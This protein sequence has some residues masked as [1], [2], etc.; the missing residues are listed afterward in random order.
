MDLRS[1]N[2]EV[3]VLIENLKSKG[4][5]ILNINTKSK[6]KNPRERTLFVYQSVFHGFQIRLIIFYMFV[7]Q[8]I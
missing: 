6:P 2:Q 7:N 8:L 5:K 1:G 4:N 3:E